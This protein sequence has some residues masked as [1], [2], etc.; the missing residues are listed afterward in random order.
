M[1]PSH[2]QKIAI[3]CGIITV[4]TSRSGKEDISGSAIETLLTEAGYLVQSKKVIPDDITAIRTT[5]I[6][7]LETCNCIITTGGTGITTDDCTIEAV[8]PLLEKELD[9]FGELFRMKSY[10]EVGTRMLL[11]RAIAGIIGKNVV[12][13]IPGSPNAAK[14]A[15]SE[16]IIPEIAH[17]LTHAS[18]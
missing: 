3:H 13:C 6:T 8:R 11:S 9:G 17:L 4:S 1:D 2:I 5:L 15:T 18:R 16:I 12:F 14:L 10:Q 7:L